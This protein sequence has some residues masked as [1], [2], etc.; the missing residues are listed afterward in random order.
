MLN[1]E[2]SEKNI[3]ENLDGFLHNLFAFRHDLPLP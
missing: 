1:E 3:P 2:C